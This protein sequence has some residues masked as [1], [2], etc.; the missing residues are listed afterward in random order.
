MKYSK[1]RDV[2]TYWEEYSVRSEGNEDL[3][4]D[5]LDGSAARRNLIEMN[6]VFRMKKEDGSIPLDCVRVNHLIQEFYDGASLFNKRESNFN[7]MVIAFLNLPPTYRVKNGVGSFVVATHTMSK[8]SNAEKVLIEGLFVADML[9][10]Q[11]GFTQIL[12]DRVFF[13]QARVNNHVW[14]T[15][16]FADNAR[17]QTSNAKFGCVLCHG[18]HGIS[19]TALH[20]CV[21]VGHRRYLPINNRIR[22][23]GSSK[24]CCPEGYYEGT[25][26]SRNQVNAHVEETRISRINYESSLKVLH[27]GKNQ[28]GVVETSVNVPYVRNRSFGCDNPVEN[29]SK[30]MDSLRYNYSLSNG[31]LV[32]GQGKK[33][34]QFFHEET[35]PW[36]KTD[37]EKCLS[38]PHADLRRQIRY[39]HVTN[40][41]HEEYVL[42]AEFR[43][44]PYKGF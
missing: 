11:N 3:F 35:F 20:K 4:T 2:V 19:R 42:E 17:V 8:N 13:H 32:F 27:N 6:E 15:P 22:W 39:K 14:D 33:N 29:L 1:Y 21:Y 28:Q 18:I 34:N 5:V 10:L 30:T 31:Q 12:G 26:E 37:F 36:L 40:D 38:Y 7:A 41:E 43:K 23:F 16:A 25:E 9:L 24:S 44:S